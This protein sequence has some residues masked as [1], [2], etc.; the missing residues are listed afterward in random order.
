VRTNHVGRLAQTAAIAAALAGMPQASAYASDPNICSKSGSVLTITIPQAVRATLDRSVSDDVVVLLDGVLADCV[1]NGNPISST[2]LDSIVLQHAVAGATVEWI[3]AKSDW[4]PDIT[5]HNDPSDTVTVIGSAG[6]DLWQGVA[7]TAP[8]I[9]LDGNAPDA[10]LV[11]D[12][13]ANLVRLLPMA[14]D[15]LV[16]LR[17]VGSALSGKVAIR[18][19]DGAD[20][21]EGGSEDD[22]VFVQGDPDPD[23][24]HPGDGYDQLHLWAPGDKVG[25]V[26]D[27]Q[28]PGGDGVVGNDDY[29]WFEFFWG[30]NG[31]D[32]FVAGPNGMAA[33]GLFG[34]D[35]FVP[36]PGDDTFYGTSPT[37][38][39]FD[40]DTAD[41]SKA[42]TGV[43][44]T[45]V[46]VDAGHDTVT[47]Y[48]T[49]QL[50]WLR[51]LVG[52]PYGDTIKSSTLLVVRPG[53][54]NDVMAFGI[55]GGRV[56]A[57]PG[58]DGDD[59]VLPGPGCGLWDYSARTGALSISDDATANDGLPGEKDNV[60]LGTTGLMVIGGSGADLIRGGNAPDELSGGPGA[61][62]LF[63]AGGNDFVDG[64]AGNDVLAGGSGSDWVEGMAGNDTVREGSP[65]ANGA[66]HLTGGVGRDTVS[67]LGR[68]SG[69]SVSLDVKQDDG[70]TGEGDRVDSDFEVVIGTDHA[71]IL[72]G[73]VI[74]DVLIGAA[75]DDLIR[76]MRGYD[77][78]VGQAGSDQL[79]GGPGHD[80]LI[81]GS[82]ND[83][84]YA[85]DSLADSL[86]GGT[87]T[88]RARRDR[89]DKLISIEGTF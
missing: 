70:A 40:L 8:G 12:G 22:D 6:A 79:V 21:V 53:L 25:A 68:H 59:S 76:G 42:P 87:G 57:E 24:V 39:S 78:L 60:G 17:D 72:T 28:S 85:L 62:R 64:Y 86:F 5:I 23:V 31:P 50:N 15:D 46:D 30:S 54:G 58:R 10:E 81:G 73:S 56:V 67:Y 16:D 32:R 29:G 36:G 7:G 47:G 71:D 61:D 52:T 38:L 1:D 44:V 84:F 69:V 89:V 75:G 19:G 2:T 45:T 65:S 43:N 74:R 51:E 13:P 27:P 77:R 4:H 14:G 20:V 9:S 66:D 41:Y 83:F 11:L 49:D 18:P 55:L 34:R 48:G 82:G 33:A 3:L 63:G 37:T 26:V 80:V 88:D 35:T